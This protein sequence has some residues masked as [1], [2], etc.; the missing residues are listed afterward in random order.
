MEQIEEWKTIEGFDEQVQVSNLGRVR[1]LGHY[2]MST[3]NKYR[4]FPTIYYT[5]KNEQCQSWVTIKFNGI[6]TILSVKDMVARCFLP[7]PNNATLVEY[8]NDATRD[9]SV[10]NL[11]WV[12]ETKTKENE[13]WKDVIGFEGL[14]QVSNLGRIKSLYNGNVTYGTLDKG[15]YMFYSLYKNRKRH[16]KLVHRLVAQSFIPNLENKPEI[17]H[18][19]CVRDDNRVENLRWVTPKENVNNPITMSRLKFRT[20]GVMSQEA[21][22]RLSKARKGKSIF[23]K[24]QIEIIRLANSKPVVQLSLNGDFIKEWVSASEAGRWLGVSSVAI[25]NCCSRKV[26]TSLGFKWYYKKDYQLSQDAS[27]VK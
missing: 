1:R 21:R 23:T 17:D 15:G 14:Y 20:R 26:N 27:K 2:K 4:F 12:E 16:R 10:S 3:S 6:S 24:E 13:V 25:R 7:N 8:I 5:F 18:I 11:R 19:N 22:E 9:N